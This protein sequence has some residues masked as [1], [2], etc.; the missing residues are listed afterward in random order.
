ME[1]F[2]LF[3]LKTILSSAQKQSLLKGRMLS[4]AFFFL[5]VSFGPALAQTSWTG[6]Q[7][8][9]WNIAANWTNGVPTAD[10]DAIIGD[11][12]FTGLNH[13]TISTSVSCKSLTLGAGAVNATL[14]INVFDDLSVLG[15]ITIG[16]LGTL[17][18]KASTITLTGNWSNQ[19]SYSP[20]HTSSTVTF[21][22]T[23]QTIDENTAFATLRINAGSTTTLI[24]G[25]NINNI[26]SVSGTLDPQL[27]QVTATDNTVDIV[28][29]D[30]GLLKV[31]AATLRENYNSAVLVAPLSTIEYASGAIDQAITAGPYGTLKISGNTVKTLLGNSVLQSSDSNVGN[32]IVASGTLNLADKTINRGTS[33]AG[34]EL[35]VA[36]GASLRIGGTNTMPANYATYSLGNTST[37]M[38]DGVDQAIAL[39]TYGHLGLSADTG[40]VTKIFPAQSLIIYGNFTSTKGTGL[41]VNYAAGANMAIYGNVS[42]G[43]STTFNAGN[44]THTVGGNWQNDGSLIGAGSTIQMDGTDKSITGVGSHNFNNLII[45]GSGIGAD[46]PVITVAGNFATAQAGSFIHRGNGTCIMSGSGKT[47]S[48]SE[49]IFQNLSIPG[50]ISTTT[51]FTIASDLSVEGAFNGQTSTVTMALGL[52][53]ISGNGS[54]LFHNLIVADS[55]EVQQN[56]SLTGNL[57]VN[58][59]FEANSVEVT[60]TGSSNS[61]ISGSYSPL[62]IKALVADK[63]IN[64]ATTSL[65]VDIHN[66]SLAEVVGGILDLKH[67]FLHKDTVQTTTHLSVNDGASLWIGGTNTL[68]FFNNYFLDSTSTV[69]YTGTEQPIYAANYGNLQISNAGEKTFDGG[70]TFI[71]GNF[72][73]SDSATANAIL[74]SSLVHYSGNRQQLV[75]AIA[76]HD[77]KL[78]G[79]GTKT[80]EAGTITIAGALGISTAVVPDAITNSTSLEFNGSNLQ[81][82]PAMD[83]YNLRSAVGTNRTLADAGTIRIKASFDPGTAVYTTTGSSVEF[84]G[85]VQQTIP[86]L[87]YHNLIINN[88]G[89]GTIPADVVVE[90]QLTLNQGKLLTGNNKVTLAPAASLSNEDNGHYV[91]GHVKI[92]QQVGTNAAT[93]GNIGLALEAGVDDLGAVTVLRTTGAAITKNGESG[94]NRIWDITAGGS[95]PAAGRKLTFSWLGDDDNS[96]NLTNLQVWRSKDLVNNNWERIGPVQAATITNTTHRH[97]SVTTDHFSLWTL[98]SDDLFT[99]PVDMLFFTG[100]RN[101]RNEAELRWATAREVY[102]QGFTIE[103]SADGAMF[104]SIGF[105]AGNGTTTQQ[106]HFSFTD[107]APSDDAY[108]RLK[109]TD[110]DGATEY[111]KVIYLP[112]MYE[113]PLSFYPNPARQHVTITGSTALQNNA[114]T[115]QAKLI[116]LQ[117][118]EVLRTRGTLTSINQA[119]NNCMPKLSAGIYYLSIVNG[120]KIYNV[121]LVIK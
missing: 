101:S 108:Y 102:N 58:N 54:I 26:L 112:S 98:R 85:S 109:Q 21:A 87:S 24:R 27:H 42:I 19:G 3:N 99:L 33:T 32:I 50:S 121:K 96:N 14:T 94:I 15:N 23:A 110:Y 104:T 81:T 73:I 106:Q 28:V 29:R 120:D 60:F 56:I 55:V 44:F 17:V 6:T 116:N 113:A 49:I 71:R 25:F 52:S 40:T 4:L 43:A 92:T 38:Y 93:F 12:N 63:L 64:S 74:N 66:L 1:D 79:G 114:G 61:E 47:I 107:Y 100:S 111:S 83:Y 7:S 41:D 95:Q 18:H 89:G 31:K 2:Y 80:F 16:L 36:N 59:V 10:I 13:P 97:V 53:N 62:R 48:G 46:A 37:V 30:N 69:A 117:G 5:L 103:R 39:H 9:D 65:G 78:G 22:G 82:I 72:I 8:T 34:G 70:E 77:L 84:N 115:L 86:V 45:N 88:A 57:T 90:G 75:R 105:V 119:M 11:L 67:F 91:V 20:Q 118:V 76:Y 51:S 35:L 68:P